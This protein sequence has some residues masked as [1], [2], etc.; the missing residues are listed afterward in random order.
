MRAINLANAELCLA[1]ANA[2]RFEMDLYK[3]DE[4][5]VRFQYDYQMS[6]P[7]LDSEGVR[8]VVKGRYEAVLG[9]Q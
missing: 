3:T 8:A 6:H 4:R 1:I 5:D 2:A 9:N 7:R